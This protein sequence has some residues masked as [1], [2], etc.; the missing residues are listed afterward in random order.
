MLN[1]SRMSSVTVQSI[2]EDLIIAL[3]IDGD[4]YIGREEFETQWNYFVQ[5]NAQMRGE[6]V[7]YMCSIHHCVL[8]V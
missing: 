6:K 5:G 1:H 3:D 4:G 2:M 8:D 7:C